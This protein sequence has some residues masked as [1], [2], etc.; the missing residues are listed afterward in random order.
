MYLLDTNILLELLLNQN[1][2]GD[3]DRLLANTPARNLYLTEFSLYSVGIILIRKK[4]SK[5]FTLMIQ[6]L[7]EKDGINVLRLLPNDMQNVADHAQKFNLDFDDAYQYAVAEKYDLTIVSFD[8]D[9]DRTARGR[10]EPAEI[11]P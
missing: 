9:F 2:A 8:R 3:V 7:I 5:A 4:K 10:K 11:V 1:K 6:E